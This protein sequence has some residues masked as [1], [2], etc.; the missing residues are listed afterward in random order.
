MRRFYFDN[1]ERQCKVFMFGGLNIK[2]INAFVTK[3][4]CMKTCKKYLLE[5][6]PNVSCEDVT[7]EGNDPM[8][9]QSDKCLPTRRF[10]FNKVSGKCENYFSRGC[11]FNANSFV[12]IDECEAR[13]NVA[14]TK[15][16][17]KTAIC[18]QPVKR[19]FCR[20]RLNRFFYDTNSGICKQFWYGGCQG[21]ENNFQDLRSCIQTCVTG[22]YLARALEGQTLEIKSPC[23]QEKEAGICKGK[24]P[25]YYFDKVSQTCKLFFFGGCGGNGN[26]FDS[27]DECNHQCPVDRSAQRALREVCAL[28]KA[29]GNCRG[30]K[31]RFF[32]NTE[33]SRCEEFSYSGCEANGNN[34]ESRDDCLLSCGLTLLL[35]NNNAVTLPIQIESTNDEN[36]VK[37]QSGPITQVSRSM[38][39]SQSVSQSNVI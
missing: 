35:N 25:K 5:E 31:R 36:K 2:G 8:A 29:V 12:S 1:N 13:C 15:I 38:S 11:R 32:F 28:P 16:L 9:G 14:K 4:S 37:D 26:R 33:N 22:D 7:E 34:F 19:G 3:N 27:L 10:R 6:N 39:V 20:S 18:N 30:A 23:E 21:N 24:A 17:G